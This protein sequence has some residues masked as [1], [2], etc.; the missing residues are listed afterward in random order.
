MTN[1]YLFRALMQE[2]NEVLKAL[3]SSL[4]HLK[5]EDILRVEVT[6]PIELGKAIN[7]KE[8]ILDVKVLMNENTILNL[9]MQVV[10]EGN[11]PERSLIYLCRAFDNLNVGESY[12]NVK[13][14]LQVGLLDFTLFPDE[15]VFFSTYHLR[16][17][18][19]HK[20]YSDKFAISVL[21]L[22]RID[23]ATDEDKHYRIDDWAKLFK[24]TTWEELK[25]I[26]KSD[27]YVEQAASTVYKLTQDEKIRQQC[28]A[29]EDYR[30]RTEGREKKLADAQNQLK[31]KDLELE[32]ERKQREQK[33]LELEQ[34]RRQ[35]EQKD[36]ELEQ[37]DIELEQKNIELEEERRQ[38]REKE[39]ELEKAL[40][41]IK[42]M[43][44]KTNQT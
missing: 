37:K 24:A 8:F 36:I 16:N 35:R 15:P 11:W 13:P 32:Q 29:R 40:A 31:Q 19:T 23:L 30:R 2:N 33:E 41:L 21:D 42:Q 5:M 38:R 4:L 10:N 6:N 39:L 43:E 14:A 1:D 34:E 7:H 3:I 44:N 9:E 27:T 12:E 17:D 18:K 26:A 25:M 28:E 22:S 20:L